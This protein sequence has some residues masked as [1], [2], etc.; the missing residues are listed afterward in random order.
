MDFSQIWK[1][2]SL[3]KFCPILQI[4]VLG[5]CIHGR[6]AV[7]GLL[8]SFKWELFITL[9]WLTSGI[10]WHS[11]SDLNIEI[12][13]EFLQIGVMAGRPRIEF[14]GVICHVIARRDQRK[15]IFAREG[16]FVPWPW[17]SMGV[18]KRGR[19]VL[20]TSSGTPYEISEGQ[21]KRREKAG[22]IVFGLRKG[23]R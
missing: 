8:L 5:S 16:D 4:F 1:L 9:Y 21:E 17:G 23:W 3:V 14:E 13:S 6:W 12:L 11:G 20:A 19:Q 15:R 10:L 7:T 2:G 18:R 22:Y